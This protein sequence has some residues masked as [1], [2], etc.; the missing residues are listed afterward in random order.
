[1]FIIDS[2]H[3]SEL[4]LALEDASISRQKP[5]IHLISRQE[6][7]DY[8]VLELSVAHNLSVQ[9][10]S[11]DSY[12]T[13]KTSSID[14]VLRLLALS[15]NSVD[16]SKAKQII[17]SLMAKYWQV[18]LSNH[19]FEDLLKKLPKDISNAVQISVQKR[20]SEVSSFHSLTRN[21]ERVDSYER[22]W[23]KILDSNN[24]LVILNGGMGT[25]KTT[26]L[27]SVYTHYREKGKF[28]ILLTAKRTIAGNFFSE[29]H[30]DH[31]FSENTERQ[32]LIGVVN[33]LARHK[34]EK[35][36][37]QCKVLLIDEVQDLF[38]H[39]SAGS[40]GKTYEDRVRVNHTISSL[41]KSVD[42]VVV[43]DAM[44]TQKTL[45]WLE[46]LI[47]SPASILNVEV[48][49][50][51]SINI[52]T[53]NQILGAVKKDLKIGKKVALFCDYR[54]E[55]FSEIYSAFA[56][57]QEIKAIAV[58]ATYFDGIGVNSQSIEKALKDSDFA[59]ISPVI[60]SGVS[61]ELSDYERVYVLAGQTLSP[62]ACLQSIRRFRCAK[63][64]CVAFR[65]GSASKRITEAFPYILRSVILDANDP[66]QEAEQYY[67]T[68]S[69]RFLAEH[70]A[71]A[72]RQ[73]KD[74]RQTFIIAAKQMGFEV[75]T[76]QLNREVRKIGAKA[77]RRGRR[78]NDEIREECAFRTAGLVS[79]GRTYEIDFGSD[80]KTFEQE[81]ALRTFKAMD[82]FAIPD[83]DERIYLE[84]F[85]FDVD[86]IVR[87]RR[88]LNAAASGS[89]GD[90]SDRLLLAAK[91]TLRFL[92][93]SGWTGSES[94]KNVIS[95]S[96][97]EA[98]FT[99]LRGVV[100]LETGKKVR[101]LDLVSA[102]FPSVD[103]TKRYKTQIVRDL[104]RELGFDLE[105]AGYSGREAAYTVGRLV[106]AWRGELVDLTCIADQYECLSS[107]STAKGVNGHM[108][109]EY[110]LIS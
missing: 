4:E 102:A 57:D 48:P 74:F 58:N 98:A 10:S 85:E 105:R 99:S 94:A 47:N 52:T 19:Y 104:M 23:G 90:F 108:T 92:S 2:N 1:M 101:A 110:D 51:L 39:V 43:A 80:L 75:C 25:F 87:N 78:T 68:P 95:R 17:C 70:A 89:F 15:N 82:L 12:S 7:T 20:E 91:Q 69:A 62:T 63:E 29:D 96:K 71:H 31:Y 5:K 67:E 6:W 45:D 32:G 36:R 84:V 66:V 93:E 60:N 26:T 38:D 64:A 33:T 86:R 41:I 72:N 109:V 61:I 97:V 81:I 103:F 16:R 9:L 88:L 42:K 46:Y 65:P 76:A 55:K 49:N 13:E 54:A 73:F 30:E 24:R 27:R 79:K 50:E 56:S 83:W 35:E 34:H 100:V 21:S 53:E 107:A 22:C 59:I 37:E 28:P 18:E 14:K 40:L 11:G 106:K 3:D 8:K 77:R 44:I